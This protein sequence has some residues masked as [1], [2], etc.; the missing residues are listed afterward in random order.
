MRNPFSWDGLIVHVA[1]LIAV[2]IFIGV[3]GL[4]EGPLS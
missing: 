1:I 4:Y 3:L 2:F